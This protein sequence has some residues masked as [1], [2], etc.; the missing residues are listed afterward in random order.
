MCGATSK[1]F[2]KVLFDRTFCNAYLSRDIAL[3]QAALN[4]QENDL[5]APWRQ[6]RQGLSE[7]VE[8]LRR[9]CLVLGIGDNAPKV[10]C[11]RYIGRIVTHNLEV[12]GVA[13]RN[14]AS[15]LV[16]QRSRLMVTQISITQHAEDAEVGLLDDFL[17][18][19][20]A[21][22]EAAGMVRQICA[23]LFNQFVEPAKLSVCRRYSLHI[24][25]QKKNCSGAFSAK[26]PMQPVAGQ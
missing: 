11:D 25:P 22:R 13:D 23:G 6:Q 26:L 20:R 24:I 21:G 14:I 3:A 15:G 2:G 5:T 18:V 16:E 8:L 10:L 7:T 19:V 1:A 9:A 4:A 17:S 12:P